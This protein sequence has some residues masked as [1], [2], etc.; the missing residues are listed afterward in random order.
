MS[1]DWMIQ[2]N[3]WD[4]ESNYT[5]GKLEPFNYAKGYTPNEKEHIDSLSVYP[6][7]KQ[8]VIYI[9]ILLIAA[10]CFA[11]DLPTVPSKAADGGHFHRANDY[12]Y[13][14]VISTPVGMA[15]KPWIGLAAGEAAGIA[16]EA[17]YG[18]NFNYGHLA[19][20]SAGALTGYALAKWEKHEQ[21]KAD[22]KYGNQ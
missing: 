9:T 17:R 19:I 10:N 5:T 15:T 20:I 1:D 21:R 2:I 16:N 8:V 7:L 18:K 4:G 22:A 13:G 14:L 3:H 11:A 6:L 12:A